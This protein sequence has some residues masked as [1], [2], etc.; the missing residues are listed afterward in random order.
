MDSNEFLNLI[1]QL[2]E[3]ATDSTL[4][5]LVTT[6]GRSLDQHMR[7]VNKVAKSLGLKEVQVNIYDFIGQKKRENTKIDKYF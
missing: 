1:E 6:E 7:E 4:M 3:W 2:P 5:N